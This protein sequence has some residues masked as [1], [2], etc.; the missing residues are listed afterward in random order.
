MDARDAPGLTVVEPGPEHDSAVEALF[1]R[2]RHP[3]RADHFERAWSDRCPT[4]IA[5]S[6]LAVL[7]AAT[8]HAFA[9]LRPAQVRGAGAQMAATVLHEITAASPEAA[10]ALLAEAATRAPLTLCAGVG[11]EGAAALEA[12]GFRPVGYFQRWAIGRDRTWPEPPAMALGFEPAYELPEWPDGFDADPVWDR[13]VRRLRSRAERQ[14]LLRGATPGIEIYS[15]LVDSEPRAYAAL[16][17]QPGPDG[18]EL[19]L[20]DG[21]APAAEGDA[22]AAGLA[23]LARDRRRPLI[24]SLLAEGWAP[25]FA[26]AGFELL[27]PRWLLHIRLREDDVILAAALLRRETW[28]LTALDA[29]LDGW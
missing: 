7:D 1:A 17:E 16:R 2:L 10:A 3:L 18:P 4:G 12:A 28:F 23:H 22:F 29:E 21:W 25:A 8:A 24:A 6:P 27:A 26:A 9:A 5:S 13:G 20:V 11:P 15:A 14:W 19:V